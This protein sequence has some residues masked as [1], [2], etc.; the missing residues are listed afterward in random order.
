MTDDCGL[1]CD[2]YNTAVLGE[3]DCTRISIMA[4]DRFSRWLSGQQNRLESISDF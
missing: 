4:K 1:L 2:A 3:R